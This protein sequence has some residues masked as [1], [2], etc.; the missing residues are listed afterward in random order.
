MANLKDAFFFFIERIPSENVSGPRLFSQILSWPDS[1]R[2]DSPRFRSAA[3]VVDPFLEFV[4]R[5]VHCLVV[6]AWWFGMLLGCRL[7]GDRAGIVRT[8]F[9]NRASCVEWWWRICGVFRRVV[10]AN[11]WRVSSCFVGEFLANIVVLCWR[12]FG[13]CLANIGEW[14]V[15]IRR[16]SPLFAI[17]RHIFATYSPKIRQIF[18]ENS[19]K[20]RQKFAENSPENS[21]QIRQQIRHKFLV[22]I[23]QKKIRHYPPA[24][25]SVGPRFDFCRDFS[26]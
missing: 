16:Y 13:E 4:K 5:S 18:A 25:I 6:V 12:I 14:F 26:G 17:I 24:K 9:A 11:F 19:P 20:I 10:L 21:P 2:L 23:L 1:P 8:S 7:G 15:D 22:R 3:G